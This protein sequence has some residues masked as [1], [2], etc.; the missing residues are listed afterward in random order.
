MKQIRKCCEQET[1]SRTLRSEAG[2]HVVE[3]R[4]RLG[5]HCWAV[6]LGM[7]TTGDIRSRSLLFKV[8][9]DQPGVGIPTFLGEFALASLSSFG[10]CLT[11]AW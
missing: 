5:R 6:P 7:I 2:Q 4:K 3:L 1:T 9:A 8:L 10:R 11:L